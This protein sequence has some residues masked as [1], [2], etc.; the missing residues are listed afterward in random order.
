MEI[1]FIVARSVSAACFG[2]FLAYVVG[3]T[4]RFFILTALAASWAFFSSML[5][6]SK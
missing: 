2:G 6:A 4:P 3:I 1:V 5:A